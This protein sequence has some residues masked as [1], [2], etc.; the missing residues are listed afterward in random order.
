MLEDMN[1]V[2]SWWKQYI[3]SCVKSEHSLCKRRLR[4]SHIYC[5][6]QQSCFLFVWLFEIRYGSIDQLLARAKNKSVIAMRGASALNDKSRINEPSKSINLLPVYVRWR[7]NSIKP[8]ICLCMMKNSRRSTAVL[9]CCREKRNIKTYFFNSA[10]VFSL[11][12]H[13]VAALGLLDV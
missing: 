3:Y 12:Y 9:S 7:I 2:F 11:H 1:F 10:G 5:W 13:V 8:L 4:V 6:H